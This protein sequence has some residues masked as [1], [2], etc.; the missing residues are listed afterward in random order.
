MKEEGGG[1]ELQSLLF[2]GR[3]RIIFNDF[4]VRARDGSG[5]IT[6]SEAYFCYGLVLNRP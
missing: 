3:I 6:S 2:V 5:R 4:D 1:S